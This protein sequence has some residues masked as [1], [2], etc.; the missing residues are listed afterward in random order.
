MEALLE[1]AASQY[2]GDVVG[3]LSFGYFKDIVLFA[4]SRF[5]SFR[6]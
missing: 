4:P 5:P 1:R 3:G 2:G 6:L